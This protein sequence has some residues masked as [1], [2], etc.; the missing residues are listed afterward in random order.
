MFS[1]TQNN[2]MCPMED[3]NLSAEE[4]H[5]IARGL[6]A[7]N[8]SLKSRLRNPEEINLSSISTNDLLTEIA[9]RINKE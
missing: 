6:A 5:R 1:E 9:R 8:A 7:E 3:C 2:F 4:E